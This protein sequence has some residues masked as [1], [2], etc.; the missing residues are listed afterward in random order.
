MKNEKITSSQFWFASLLISL[1]AVMTLNNNPN[2]LN[3]ALCAAALVVDIVF[4]RFYKGGGGKS[5]KIVAGVYLAALSSLSLSRFCGYMS[6][7]LGYGHFV[8]IIV[9]FC[10][11]IFFCTVKGLEP[12][13]RAGT[14]TGVLVICAVVYMFASSYGHIR[15]AAAADVEMNYFAPLIFLA[16]MFSYVLLYD[17]VLPEKKKAELICPA[18]SLVLFAYF[19]FSASGAPGEF[20]VHYVTIHAKLGVFKGADCL[21]L[22]ILTLSALYTTAISTA[23]VVGKRKHN[24]IANSVFIAAVGAA[25]WLMDYV[26]ANI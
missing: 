22:A 20:P 25:A 15:W 26:S 6:R 10:G 2:V 7:E 17:N 9:V 1:S 24:Y 11:F 4:V 19:L 21:L 16:P 12:I 14:I 3:I 23:A 13:A 8:L 18:I 5:V